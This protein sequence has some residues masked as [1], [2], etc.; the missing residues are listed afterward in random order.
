MKI[1]LIKKKTLIK[2]KYLLLHK[3]PIPLNKFTKLNKNN[4]KKIINWLNIF[5]LLML[6]S[7][8]IGAQWQ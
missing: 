1:K 5:Y 7:I 4:Y 6:Y 8:H 2:P 3:K